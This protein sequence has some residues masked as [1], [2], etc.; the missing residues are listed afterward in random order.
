M[1]VGNDIS[2]SIFIDSKAKDTE[3]KI[4]NLPRRVY[5]WVDDN[6]VIACYSCSKQFGFFLRR[7]HCRFCG[8]IFCSNCTNYSAKIPKDLLSNDAE[9]GTW[10]EYLSS[11]IVSKDP[12]RYKV[13]KACWNLIEMINSVKK[14]IEAFVVLDL[15]IKEVKKMAHV[16]RLWSSA[17]GYVLGIFREVQYRLPGWEYDGLERRIIWNSYRYLAGHSRYVVHL[18]KMCKSEEEF[19]KGVELLRKKRIVNCWSLMCSRGCKTELIAMD[20]IGLLCTFY[21]KIGCYDLLKSTV[22]KY[23]KCSD[24]EF[25]CYLPVLVYYLRYDSGILSDFLLKRCVTSFEL[26]NALN[27]E[28]QLYL[29]DIGYQDFLKKLKDVIGK[30]VNGTNC[31]RIMEGYSFVKVVESISK[32]ICEDKKGYDDI[33]DCFKMK[34]G[35]TVPVGK[36]NKVSDIRVERIKIKDSASKPLMIPCG[37]VGDKGEMKILYKKECVRKDQ[38]VVNLV[39]LISEIVKMEEGIDL[40]L[41][42]YG[43]LPLGKSCGLVEIVDDSETVYY[44]QEKLKSSIMNYVLENNDEV[45]VRD[46][47]GRLV[48]TMAAYC[49]ITYLL[50]IGDRHL[51]NIMVT[52]DGRLFH[53]DFGY[54]MGADPVFNDPGIRITNEMID[55]LGGMSSKYYQQFTEKC[56]IIYNCLR[57]HIDL[58]IYVLE[59]LPE[60]TDIGLTREQI[61]E[62]LIKRF[63]PGENSVDAK[64]H[65]VSQLENQSYMNQV[66]DWFHYH[67]KEKTISSAM[68][69]LSYAVSGLVSFS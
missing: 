24:L 46:I 6:S 66:K 62:Q 61:R 9:K 57:R 64:L 22:I 37:L 30:E 51:D 29:E 5:T 48:G 1:Q 55:A 44:I 59:L 13:C 10:N 7:H 49:V 63:I 69:R 52:K 26:L 14:L 60:L 23:L 38:I 41:V 28:L 35:L 32:N 27:W 39:V 58:F 36:G 15:D 19:Q 42:V 53:I 33:K 68:S 16:C 4:L 34:G 20:V 3:A 45:K 43:V 67:S 8:K 21:G 18:L 47:K 40:E 65:L 56:S 11:Y 31:V 2:Y 17:C 12:T 25:K 50:G 54:I